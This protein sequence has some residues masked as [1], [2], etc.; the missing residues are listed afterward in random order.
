VAKPM[1]PQRLHNLIAEVVWK[2]IA[3]PQWLGQIRS[4]MSD[5]SGPSSSS[6]HEPRS[7]SP[8]PLETTQTT[9]TTR[10]KPLQVRP[11]GLNYH[12]LPESRMLELATPTNS[13]PAPVLQFTTA[14][15]A[16]IVDGSVIATATFHA[17]ETHTNHGVGNQTDFTAP[18][19]T[20]DIIQDHPSATEPATALEDLFFNQTT[21]EPSLGDTIVIRSPK[22]D[23]PPSSTLPPDHPREQKETDVKAE[24][25]PERVQTHQDCAETQSSSAR[26]TPTMPRARGGVLKSPTTETDP[27]LHLKHNSTSDETSELERLL[28][29][30]QRQRSIH[31]DDLLGLSI[32]DHPSR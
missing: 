22:V 2:P 7:D 9:T 32:L 11:A 6:H 31:N 26:Q 5:E 16:A 13:D 14:E 20:T 19:S 25:E 27:G 4:R 23:A 21:I 30:Y 17:G 1:A 12:G 10:R 15:E 28:D 3:V 8:R 18:T 29:Q 24:V